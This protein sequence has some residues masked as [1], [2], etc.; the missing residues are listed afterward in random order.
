MRIEK[1]DFGNWKIIVQ[2]IAISLFSV[3]LTLLVINISSMVVSLG[4]LSSLVFMSLTNALFL[5]VCS[6]FFSLIMQ[7]TVLEVGNHFISSFIP[8]FHSVV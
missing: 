6:Y 3:I 4:F 2:R 5:N 8:S 1:Q 7:L